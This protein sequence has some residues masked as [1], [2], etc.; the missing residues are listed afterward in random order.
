MN[1]FCTKYCLYVCF[2]MHTVMFIEMLMHICVLD[3]MHRKELSLRY[4]LV[5]SVH[6]P[7]E[8]NSTIPRLFLFLVLSHLPGLSTV[9]ISQDPMGP[10]TVYSL[11]QHQQKIKEDP[12]SYTTTRVYCRPFCKRN[13]SDICTRL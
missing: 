13:K 8:V 4:P 7:L 5:I 9:V 11:N 2:F 3:I 10:W 12:V 1:L 6:T